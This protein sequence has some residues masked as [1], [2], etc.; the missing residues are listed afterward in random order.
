MFGPP[1]HRVYLKTSQKSDIFLRHLHETIIFGCVVVI[2]KLFASVSVHYIFPRLIFY[3][4]ICA[5]KISKR[6]YEKVLCHCYCDLRITLLPKQRRCLGKYKHTLLS[7]NVSN[8]V[9]FKQR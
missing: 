9:V 7:N 8:I 6:L 4:E 1:A 3:T 5:K 2:F